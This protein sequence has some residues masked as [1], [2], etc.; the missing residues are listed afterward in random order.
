MDLV[1]TN[2]SKGAKERTGDTVKYKAA[3]IRHA[4]H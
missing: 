4:G 1:S 3:G 2:H